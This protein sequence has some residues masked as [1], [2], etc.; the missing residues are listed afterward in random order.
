MVQNTHFGSSITTNCFKKFQTRN[1]LI[2]FF[3]FF[4]SKFYPSSVIIAALLLVSNFRTHSL[5][6]FVLY[7]ECKLFCRDGWAGGLVGVSAVARECHSVLVKSWAYEQNSP[8]QPRLRG[9]KL[10]QRTVYSQSLTR[11]PPSP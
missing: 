9:E 4:S 5:L 7:E 6:F 3:F 2:C 1:V 10:T 8:V 11:E